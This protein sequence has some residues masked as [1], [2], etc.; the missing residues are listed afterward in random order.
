MNRTRALGL[1]ALLAAL[2]LAGCS[3]DATTTAPAVETTDHATTVETG[4]QVTPASGE[5]PTAT[6]P[7]PTDRQ[8]TEQAQTPTTITTP[9]SSSTAVDLQVETRSS[10][11]GDGRTIAGNV[12]RF[13]VRMP[14]F[15]NQT[16]GIW[17]YVPPNYSR[18]TAEYP[19]VYIQDGQNVFDRQ[20]SFVGEWRAD[21]TMQR[22]DSEQSLDAIVVAVENGGRQRA[23]E[24]LPW[25]AGDLGGG[26][27]DAYAAFL[28]ET[29]VPTIDAHYRTDTDERAVVGSSLGGVIS[30]YTAF[31][32]PDTFQY[33][34]GMSN[35]HMYT[36]E[37]YGWLNES[38]MGPERVYLDWGTEE[39]SS[40]ETVVRA[41]QRLAATVENI[42]YVRGEG[43][44]AV[45]DEGAEHNEGAWRER[46]PRAIEWLLT[47]EDPA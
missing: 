5:T 20:A 24:Y 43:L 1:C 36:P 25:E 10:E 13:S 30:L 40:P 27:G 11:W 26:D 2:A 33:V 45:E 6:T 37:V 15:E 18:S 7:T 35:A 41:N 9:P 42:G 14:Q 38:G 31:E 8:T 46:F 19:V 22:L 23:D 32:Y 17:V 16:R 12:T 34:G 39:G 44:L 29:L 28:A 47:G 4:Q 21:E 3:T